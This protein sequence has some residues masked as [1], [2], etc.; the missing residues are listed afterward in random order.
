MV[1][2]LCPIR[3]F[4][5]IFYFGTI[6]GIFTLDTMSEATR[7][8]VAA[9]EIAM[10]FE[11]LHFRLQGNRGLRSLA[12][13]IGGILLCAPA[14]HAQAAEANPATTQEQQ[15]RVQEHAQ[16]TGGAASTASAIADLDPVLNRIGSTLASLEIS[17]WKLSRDGRATANSDVESIQQDL[18]KTLPALM[19]TAKASGEQVAP[20]FAVYRNVDALYDVLLRVT[21]LAN[22]TAPKAEA[23]SI[24][25][26]RAG[27]EAARTELGQAL[28]SAAA[29]QDSEVGRLRQAAARR[30]P[31]SPPKTTIINDGPVR[32]HV[33]R[34]KPK[35]HA[36]PAT[37]KREDSQKSAD[38]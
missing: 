10:R 2:N 13:V 35:A 1:R 38:Q 7:Q 21:A 33:T 12:L 16:R 9:F 14:L 15:A 36:K 8:A 30:P 31:P 22:F 28:A 34:A 4:G 18:G 5:T 20:T 23:R 6:S 17:D 19:E 24:E 27:L 29:E 26:A 3:C 32:K 37:Q 11:F 25:Q